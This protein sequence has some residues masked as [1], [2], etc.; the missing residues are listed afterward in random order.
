MSKHHRAKL[1]EDTVRKIRHLHAAG[2]SQASIAKQFGV[3]QP[4]IGQIVQ[5]ATWRH[6][7]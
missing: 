2:K 7:K 3:S 4:A 5:R 6:V 1:T